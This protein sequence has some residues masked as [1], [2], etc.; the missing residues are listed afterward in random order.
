MQAV[1]VA[2][3]CGA[4]GGDGDG[5][6]PAANTTQLH[7]FFLDTAAD[8]PAKQLPAGCSR[9][10]LPPALCGLVDHVA[11]SFSR[12][13]RRAAGRSR[14]RRNSA[15][16]TRDTGMCVCVCVCLG[17]VDWQRGDLQRSD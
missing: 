10:A 16:V 13:S 12:E 7:Q 2:A 14:G 5:E 15:G 9:P 6:Q 11:R 3:A 1:A 8:W 17:G 4:L